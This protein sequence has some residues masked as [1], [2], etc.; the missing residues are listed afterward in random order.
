MKSLRRELPRV[1]AWLLKNDTDWL[2]AN[3]PAR[4]VREQV[5]SS[6][7]WGWRDA[8]LA[9]FIWSKAI[10]L[11]NAPGKPTF[12][13]RTAICNGL[14]IT[15]LIRQKIQKLPLTAN[16]LADVAESRIEYAARRVQWAAQCYLQEG[17]LPLRWN[18]I[19]RANVYRW[20]LA[21]KITEALNTATE[22]LEQAFSITGRSQQFGLHSER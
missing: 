20:T 19:M 21:P 3:R 18:L 11:L 8:K 9:F 15:S 6:V 13:S 2:K 16:A 5:N 14:G 7:D 1:Y 10:E 12:L 22:L 17:I 4:P